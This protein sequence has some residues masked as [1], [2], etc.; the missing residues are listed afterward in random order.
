MALAA[1]VREWAERTLDRGGQPT[2]HLRVVPQ[3][4]GLVAL[5][6]NG[7]RVLAFV[8]IAI[9]VVPLVTVG[10]FRVAQR[11]LVPPEVA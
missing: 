3:R 11:S 4:F 9:Y 10:I 5:I 1:R 6:A 2:D 8:L 7:Y